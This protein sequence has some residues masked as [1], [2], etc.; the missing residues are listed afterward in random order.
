MFAAGVYIRSFSHENVSRVAGDRGWIKADQLC[1]AGLVACSGAAQRAA[2]G[3]KGL[4][5]TE[6][7]GWKNAPGEQS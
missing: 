6:E 2:S 3:W 1:S 5:C 7:R 4:R